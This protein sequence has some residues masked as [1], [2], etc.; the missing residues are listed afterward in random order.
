MTKFIR[1]IKEAGVI[2]IFKQKKYII[3]REYHSLLYMFSKKVEA[4]ENHSG[5]PL[6]EY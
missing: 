4:K 2:T 6:F 3:L 5:Q 1:W